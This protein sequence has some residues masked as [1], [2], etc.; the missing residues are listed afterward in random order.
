MPLTYLSGALVM[1]GDRIPFHG[2]HGEVEF[3]RTGRS[4]YNLVHASGFEVAAN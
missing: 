3:I 2:E 4:P 1:T